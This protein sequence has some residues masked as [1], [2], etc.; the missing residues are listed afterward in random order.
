MRI[1]PTLILTLAT[2]VT[3]A[4]SATDVYRW[5]D[6]KGVTHYSDTPPGDK[7]YE[8]V[9]VRTGKASAPEQ[10]IDADADAEAEGDAAPA[11]QAAPDPAIARAE[12]CK[13]AQT[14]LIALRSNFDV[15]IEINGE[16]RPLSPEEREQQIARNEEAETAN[17]EG[18]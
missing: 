5:T 8:R 11:A 3:G 18:Q 6:E 15:N 12:R 17:C 1:L 4:A 16:T 14:N 10:A 9:N 2:C 7:K 13:N